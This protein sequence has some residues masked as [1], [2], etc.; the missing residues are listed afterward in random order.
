M[1]LH[2]LIGNIWLLTSYTSFMCLTY[3]WTA[4]HPGC[5]LLR[6]QVESWGMS[7]FICVLIRSSYK[8]MLWN[9]NRGFFQLAWGATSSTLSASLASWWGGKNATWDWFC[10][11]LVLPL[12]K[13]CSRQG[14][15]SV[16]ISLYNKEDMLYQSRLSNPSS[17]VTLVS[18]N[19]MQ[20]WW[21]LLACCSSTSRP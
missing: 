18:S 16:T 21:C 20:G 11:F 12:S 13:F 4:R 2:I 9:T 5:L 17:G 10:A 14:S 1:E 7:L 15:C 6:N 19:L 8:A 3:C